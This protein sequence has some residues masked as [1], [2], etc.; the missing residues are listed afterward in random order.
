MAIFGK[1]DF[2]PSNLIAILLSQR[3][4][5]QG[6]ERG[7]WHWTVTRLEISINISRYLTRGFVGVVVLD[8]F[9]RTRIVVG[10]GR[11]PFVR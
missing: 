2:E 10:N 11:S 5:F 6:V 9:Q 1:E 8:G 4:I 3:R 7:F